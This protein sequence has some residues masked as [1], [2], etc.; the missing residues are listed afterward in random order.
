MF[1]YETSYEL[2][3]Y[4]YQLVKDRNNYEYKKDVSVKKLNNIN[5]IIEYYE[6]VLGHTV[7]KKFIKYVIMYW[8]IKDKI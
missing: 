8:V 3:D 5:N 7:P 6:L 4:A 1:L 2:M